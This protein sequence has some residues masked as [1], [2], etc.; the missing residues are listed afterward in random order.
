[1]CGPA[2]PN[3]PIKAYIRT[4]FKTLFRAHCKIQTPLGEHKPWHSDYTNVTLT[5]NTSCP[6]NSDIFTFKMQRKQKHKKQRKLKSATIGRKWELWQ[7]DVGKM[8]RANSYPKI[9][10]QTCFPTRWSKC[11]RFDR[12][13]S[14]M[15]KRL[16]GNMF[17]NSLS[18][19]GTKTP[20]QLL[21]LFCAAFFHD[22]HD[23]HEKQSIKER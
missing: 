22:H 11:L 4:H 10:G 21:A 1:M 6:E 23:D 16:M 19:Y 2:L 17:I 14:K 9:K 12:K 13:P 18:K 8:I 20:N 7:T 15:D 3:W 5:R